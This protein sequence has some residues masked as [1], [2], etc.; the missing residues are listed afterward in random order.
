M[1]LVNKT[2]S[3]DTDDSTQIIEYKGYVGSTAA[4][5]V[6]GARNLR[7]STHA[8]ILYHSSPRRLP[9]Y[10]EWQIRHLVTTFR[11]SAVM[12]NGASHEKSLAR[13]AQEPF[14]RGLPLRIH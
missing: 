5:L 8:P 9:G 4:I 14:K 12:Q 6:R 13:D 11:V 2:N 10:I 7:I 1:T 3:R